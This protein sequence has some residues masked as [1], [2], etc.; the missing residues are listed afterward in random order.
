MKKGIVSY[1]EA[2]I[3]Y[4]AKDHYNKEY[5]LYIGGTTL[6]VAVGLRRLGTPTYYLCKLGT[7]CVSAYVKRELTKEKVN[8]EYCI[9]SETKKI[10]GVYVHVDENGERSFHSYVNE[11]PDEHLLTIELKE[12]LFK[13]AFIFYCGSG[14]L[15]HP[16][17]YE[18]TLAAI[19]LA[20]KNHTL[21]AFDPNIRMKRWESEKDCRE[22][23]ISILP[24]VSI[25]KISE[26]ELLFLMDVMTM[27]EG[28]KKLAAYKIPYVWVTCAEKGAIVIQEDKQI[29]VP[30]LEVEVID[31]TG[32]GDAFMAG[33]LHCIQ[34]YGLPRSD[35]E[36]ITYTEY[37][38]KLGALA[39]TKVGA[40]SAFP[41]ADLQKSE[42]N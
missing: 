36:L 1:G 15:F 20:Q 2:F 33:I 10:C 19:K 5:E 6:N 21:I 13:K 4:I 22:K 12:E 28:S 40:L 11:T 41:V 31:S 23:I 32:A 39:S 24:S 9:E 25:L 37:G 7:D 42:S 29:Y 27:D 17:A 34:T 35:K 38:N 30:G 18:T 3:D 26:E 16:I 8:Q 14:T